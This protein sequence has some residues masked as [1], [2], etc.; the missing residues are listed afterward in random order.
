MAT[1]H[2]SIP[3]RTRQPIL[4]QLAWTRS[5]PKAFGS[6]PRPWRQRSC[7]ARGQ[8][9]DQCWSN[10]ATALQ[11]TNRCLSEG[12]AR[13]YKGLYPAAADKIHLT[14]FNIVL[15]L[16]QTWLNCFVS[17]RRL[18]IARKR[19]VKRFLIITQVGCFTLL[20]LKYYSYLWNILAYSSK[21]NQR[22][23][24]RCLMK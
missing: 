23:L 4:A 14:G 16:E 15:L 3:S 18:H 20:T 10:L 9:N 17:K 22:P 12:R 2:T 21:L 7:Y 13:L 1:S 11:S 24:P 6:Q 8:Q 5:T 19:N